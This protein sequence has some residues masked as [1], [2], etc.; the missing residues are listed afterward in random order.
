[1]GECLHTTKANHDI[2]GLALGFGLLHHGEVPEVWN[3]ARRTGVLDPDDISLPRV[4]SPATAA[5]PGTTRDPEGDLLPRLHG[6]DECRKVH[7]A[8]D[9][10]TATCPDFRVTA[11]T[12]FRS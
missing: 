2:A 6:G 10:E 5:W 1:M 11:S 12:T 3:L 8:A 9:E 4:H 7:R